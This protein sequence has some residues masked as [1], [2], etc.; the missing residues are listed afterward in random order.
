[1]FYSPGG[2]SDAC[3]LASPRRFCFIPRM[4]PPDNSPPAPGPPLSHPAG[5]PLAVLK[6]KS[7]L[8]IAFGARRL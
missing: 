2:V 3:L 5:V 1:M 6:V 8:E 4:L 7:K